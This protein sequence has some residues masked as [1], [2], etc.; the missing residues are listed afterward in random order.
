[1]SQSTVLE[2]NAPEAGRSKPARVSGL[3]EKRSDVQMSKEQSNPLLILKNSLR[4]RHYYNLETTS[5]RDSD[6]TLVFKVE[7]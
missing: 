4:N 1:M 6:L 5:F 2:Q 3:H 7:A